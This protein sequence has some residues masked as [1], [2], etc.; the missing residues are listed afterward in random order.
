MK[1]KKIKIT[2]FLFKNIISKSKF[3]SIIYLAIHYL[4][5]FVC[6]SI[7][8]DKAASSDRLNRIGLDSPDRISQESP[9]RTALD[10]PDRTNWTEKMKVLFYSLYF[11][12]WRQSGHCCCVCAANH[13]EMQCK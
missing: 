3:N 10:S 8:D 5:V 2:N 6:F 4:Y 11:H 12:S 13:L 9:D 1:K 7:I